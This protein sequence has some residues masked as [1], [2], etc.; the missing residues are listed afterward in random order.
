MSALS[1]SSIWIASG[2]SAG[3]RMPT[4]IAGTGGGQVKTRCIDVGL[5]IALAAFALVFVYCVIFAFRTGYVGA[6]F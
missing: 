5:A 6:P 2:R 3:R 1:E 4:Y